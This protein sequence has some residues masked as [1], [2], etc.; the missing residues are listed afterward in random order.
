MFSIQAAV[1]V[2][3]VALALGQDY[4]NDWDGPLNFSC[5]DGQ[6]LSFLNSYHI[7]YYED[8]RWRFGCRAANYGAATSCE[9]T[10]DYVNNYDE[11]VSYLCPANMALAGVASVHSN[12]YEDRRMKFKCCN[13]SAFKVDSCVLTSELH[14]PDKELKYYVP[15]GKVIAGWVSEHFGPSEDRVHRMILCSYSH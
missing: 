11:P 9:W 5:P 6:L 7:N 2:A 12:S 3:V 14:K 10:K 1:L 15:A 8:R 4:S 13:H